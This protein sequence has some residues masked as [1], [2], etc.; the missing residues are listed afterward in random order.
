MSEVTLLHDFQIVLFKL[1][2]KTHIYKFF[3]SMAVI[4]YFLIV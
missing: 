3:A 4:I 1:T 2:I